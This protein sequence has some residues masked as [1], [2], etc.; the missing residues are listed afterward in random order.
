MP[1]VL[2]FNHPHQRKNKYMLSNS[3]DHALFEPVPFFSFVMWQ[4]TGE[5]VKEKRKKPI[6]AV[7]ARN[8]DSNQVSKQWC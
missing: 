8:R 1:I 4:N 2:P 5:K 3:K 6:R 7:E